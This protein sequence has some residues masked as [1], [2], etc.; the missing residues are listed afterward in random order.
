MAFD[1]IELDIETSNPRVRNLWYFC[2]S[3]Y[4]WYLVPPCLS[5]MLVVSEIGGGAIVA[6]GTMNDM[7]SFSFYLCQ[8]FLEI[9]HED[10]DGRKLTFVEKKPF[11]WV[12]RM[13]WA[14]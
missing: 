5:L 11:T 13:S 1:D 9:V 10:E 3:W 2:N 7:K 12:Q 6:V 14:E 4:G 8:Y